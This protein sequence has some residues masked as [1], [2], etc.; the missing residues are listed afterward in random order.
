MNNVW[1]GHQSGNS[2][3]IQYGS[4]SNSFQQQNRNWHEYSL[5]PFSIH[6][7]S[8]PISLNDPIHLDP[9]SLACSWLTNRK[10]WR[11]ALMGGASSDLDSDWDSEWVEPGEVTVHWIK[12]F[13]RGYSTIVHHRNFELACPSADETEQESS[14]I[15]T[16][17]ATKLP[18]VWLHSSTTFAISDM[19]IS[20]IWQNSIWSVYHSR[21]FR[22]KLTIR[23]K[24]SWVEHSD[25]CCYP[26]IW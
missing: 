7:N 16:I 22:S 11:S 20:M 8:H 12:W 13:I 17:S 2:S 3:D 18:I 5:P 4:W 6:S 14:Q 9:F 24:S 10:S 1:K 26:C 23:F 19:A 21:S 15:L 25:W